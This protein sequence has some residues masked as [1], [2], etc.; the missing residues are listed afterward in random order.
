MMSVI[1]CVAV[2]VF[3]TQVN[4]NN[5]DEK[6]LEFPGQIKETKGGGQ[7]NSMRCTESLLNNNG[8]AVLLI[9]V[10]TCLLQATSLC[11]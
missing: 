3:Q 10:Q 2:A 9:D 6:L 11:S 4:A 5:C 1:S 8:I 7:Q